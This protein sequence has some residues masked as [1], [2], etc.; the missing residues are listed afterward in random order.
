MTLAKQFTVVCCQALKKA[1]FKPGAFF[2]GVVLPLC[3]VRLV[4]NGVY[5]VMLTVRSK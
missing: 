5:I 1:L 2:K 4:H 3:E